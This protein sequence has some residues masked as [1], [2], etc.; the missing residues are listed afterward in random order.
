MT[1][2][3]KANRW[4]SRYDFPGVTGNISIHTPCLYLCAQLHS[5][6]H[7]QTEIYSLHMQDTAIY[8]SLAQAK[9]LLCLI[10]SVL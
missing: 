6:N 10:N 2:R 5:F 9:N 8:F 7:S 4:L 1:Q 3:Y